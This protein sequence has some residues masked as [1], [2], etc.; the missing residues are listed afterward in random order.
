M[1]TRNIDWV[2]HNDYLD[3]C[4][5]DDL[6]NLKEFIDKR[7]K[8]IQSEEKVGIYGVIG[9]NIIHGWFKSYQEAYDCFVKEVV[10]KLEKEYHVDDKVGIESKRVP[11]SE[12]KEHIG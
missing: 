12:V 1:D 5:L 2:S 4:D 11:E 6:Y 10:P 3:S 7:I 8:K 9:P